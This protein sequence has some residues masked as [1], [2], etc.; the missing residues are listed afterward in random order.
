[1]IKRKENKM[2][3]F[4]NRFRCLFLSETYKELDRSV[5]G[6][7][8]PSIT[9]GVIIQQ[10]PL[11]EIYLP[12]DSL[13]FSDISVNFQLDEDYTN[14]KTMM[15]WIFSNKNFYQNKQ[16]LIF[17]DMSIQLGNKKK[18]MIYSI[19]L[20]DMFP[21]D[22]SSIEFVTKTDDIEPI[23]FQCQFKVNNLKFT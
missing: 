13:E 15:D 12:G 22:M 9:T 21:F 20:F 17:S 14:W 11:K 1:M 18:N 7:A 16:E 4:F 5:I 19:Q 8:I 2:S 23:E 3:T 6:V 10:T